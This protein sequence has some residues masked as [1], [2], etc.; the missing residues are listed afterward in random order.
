MTY[1]PWVRMR[2]G[3]RTG[4]ERRVATRNRSDPFAALDEKTEFALTLGLTSNTMNAAPEAVAHAG[5]SPYV[6]RRKIVLPR[7]L[8]GV[9]PTSETRSHSNLIP[10]HATLC[11]PAVWMKGEP[12]ARFVA[13]SGRR[14]HHEPV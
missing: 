3:I 10:R 1:K 6:S 7:S 13:Q 2:V 5:S 9:N 12:H 8:T 4:H 14:S 11:S